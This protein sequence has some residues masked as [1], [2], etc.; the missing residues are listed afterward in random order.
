M[1]YIVNVFVK[2]G[3]LLVLRYNTN[4]QLFTLITFTNS[5]FYDL[6]PKQ[7]IFSLR[8]LRISFPKEVPAQITELTLLLVSHA[9]T[10]FHALYVCVSIIPEI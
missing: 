10:P 2:D 3:K 6:Q 1:Y 7:E 4:I 9:I 8:L 5:L